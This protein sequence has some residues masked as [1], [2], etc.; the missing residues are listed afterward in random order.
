MITVTKEQLLEYITKQPNDRP[1][2][3]V[4]NFFDQT[5]DK[6]GCL[7]VQYAR[8]NFPNPSEYYGCGFSKWELLEKGWDDEYEVNLTGAILADDASITNI[9]LYSCPYIS[10]QSCKTYGE[11]KQLLDIK[12]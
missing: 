1:I 4:E 3:F 8:D 11:I 12:N 7:M 5:I 6:C 10:L 9:F 2:N